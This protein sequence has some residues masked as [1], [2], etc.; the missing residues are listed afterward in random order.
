MSINFRSEQ[1]VRT[2]F[3]Q[4]IKMAT[5]ASILDFDERENDLKSICTFIGPS[6]PIY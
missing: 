4:K 1:V 2:K 6:V 5:I 3:Q